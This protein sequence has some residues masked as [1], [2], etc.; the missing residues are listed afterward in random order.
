M[1]RDPERSKARPSIPVLLQCGICLWIG[2]LLAGWLCEAVSPVLVLLESFAILFICLAFA[3]FRR[4]IGMLGALVLRFVFVCLG[5]MLVAAQFQSI[6][7][8]RAVLSDSD[9]VPCMMRVLDDPTKGVFGYHATALVW[10]NG[11]GL[12]DRVM[13]AF[14]VQVMLDDGDLEFGDE[15]QAVVTFSAVDEAAT[16]YFD[17]QGLVSRCRI[18][19]VQRVRPSNL[20]VLT[21]VREY[22]ASV[23]DAALDEHW[24]DGDALAVLRALVVGDRRALFEGNLYGDVKVSGL[25]H[26]VAVSGAHLV[27]VMGLV[28]CVLRTLRVPGR[29]SNVVQ[30]LFLMGYLVMVGFPVSCIRAAVM[31]AV[32]L[33][34]FAFSKRSYALGSLGA[35]V[36][37]LLLLDVSAA[38]SISFAL[39]ALSTLGII[40][41][42][43]KF[44][45][46][47]PQA[48]NRVE[49][50]IL[51]PFAMTCAALLVTFPLSISSFSQ[52]SLVSPVSN[53]IAAP[54][55]T[56]ACA[57][58]VLSFIAMPFA[59]LCNVLLHGAYGC[60]AAFVGA[61]RM[62]ASVPYASIPVDAPFLPLALCSIALC[63]LLW[64]C[65]PKA[66]PAKAFTCIF[67]VLAVVGTGSKIVDAGATSVT[68][69]DVGQGDAF[70]IKSKGSTMLIDTG[71]QPKKLYSGLARHGVRNLDAV[72]ISHADDD[73]CGCLSDLRGVVGV[74]RVYVARGMDDVG[75]SKSHGLIED[76]ESV[77]GSDDVEEL[78]AGD[79][80]SVGAVSFTV[81]SPSMLEDEGQNE[82]SLC[83]MGESDLNGDGTCEWRMLFAGDAE[84][85][86]LDELA[87]KKAL[88][89]IDIL[90][91]SHHGSKASLDEG[92][93]K[94]MSPEVALISVGERN[95][96]GH[97]APRTLE[98]LESCDA[99]VFRSDMQGDVVCS[100]TME[101]IAVS[102]MK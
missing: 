69:I 60:A 68:M 57:V 71:N 2:C 3:L 35:A 61:V 30:L 99:K 98:L 4:S 53:I 32:G 1:T 89:D 11:S 48:G 80:L 55:V 65:W 5:V 88:D 74:D 26:L 29:A 63:A 81:L 75:T 8:K 7:A 44:I 9:P 14:K 38:F 97:P 56:A 64:A 58:G 22:Y 62:L 40:L 79:S 84:S 94:A 83:L 87:H 31:T 37:A 47:M 42:T 25:A 52:F 43:P 15:F 24:I 82:D 17:Q 100:L 45:S 78:S 13:K 73:H 51:E 54:L 49:S 33:F 91:V 59:P 77:A 36:I 10:E 46:W 102:T 101:N 95:R 66:F 90:K 72:L 18:A 41:F 93:I 70:L 86:V 12:M 16:S 96:Y 23:V 21:D 6:H 27:I 28:G 50:L 19:Q 76:A 39:S 92:L 67:L 85:D 34:S 20:G